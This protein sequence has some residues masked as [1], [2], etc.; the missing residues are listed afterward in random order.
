MTLEE[1]IYENT[2]KRSE[3]IMNHNLRL[4][5]ERQ[6][7]GNGL[8]IDNIDVKIIGLLQQDGRMANTQIAQIIGA[9]EGTVRKRIKRLV[10]D[11]V[12]QVVAVADPFKIG[13]DIAAIIRIYADIK[14]MDYVCE[15]LKKIKEMWYIALA[16]GESAY[17]VEVYLPNIQELN[18]LLTNRIWPINGVIKTETSLI[19]SYL[20]REYTWITNIH[21]TI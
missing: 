2:K 14:K 4:N 1:F 16:L 10:D 21:S 11:K 18:S 19:L 7:K 9:S 15:E 17:D 8:E 5:G 6:E 3:N 20:K 13:I 12:I